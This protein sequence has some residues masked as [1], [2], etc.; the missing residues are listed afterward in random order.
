MRQQFDVRHPLFRPFWRRAVIVGAMSAWTVYEIVNG[1]TV[2]ALAFGAASAYL[3]YE[4]FVVF[5]PK[6][7]EDK[8]DP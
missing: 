7:Y 5:D 1:N 2:W 4:F 6:N 3:A 8:G